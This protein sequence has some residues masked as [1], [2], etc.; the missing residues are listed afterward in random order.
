MRRI[1]LGS[2]LALPA[3][4]DILVLALPRYNV[5][6]STTPAPEIPLTFD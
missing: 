2:R 1:S 4:N 3:V 5:A 6:P